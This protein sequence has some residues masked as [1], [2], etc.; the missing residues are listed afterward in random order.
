MFNPGEVT[1]RSWSVSFYDN[2][3]RKWKYGVL[4][5]TP[6]YIE[7]LEE[8]TE[9]AHPYI[10]LL[11][12]YD[13]TDIKKSLTGLV[14]R[15]L[16]ITL[17][18][19]TKYWVSSL[20]DQTS[21][22]N[23]L[24]YFQHQN[25]FSEAR[26]K[27][28][29][30]TQKSFVQTEMGRKL[31]HSVHD[32]ERVL[33]NAVTV[34]HEQGTQIESSLATMHDINNDLDIADSIVSGLDSWLGK[35]KI[36]QQYKR[37]SLEI[38]QSKDLPTEL[39]YEILYT[40]LDMG[41]MNYQHLGILRV[42]IQGL[43]IMTEK[44]KVVHNFDWRAI[45]LVKV[46]SLCEI[47]VTQYRIGQQDLTYDFVCTNFL[48]VLRLLDAKLKSKV[49]FMEDVF[50]EEKVKRMRKQKPLIDSTGMAKGELFSK[51]DD[52]TPICYDTVPA[53]LAQ[54]SPGN[55]CQEGAEVL[56]QK[57]IVTDEEVAEISQTLQ[58]IKSVALSTQQELDIQ[59]DN[60]EKLTDNVDKANQRVKET[61][62][63]I[64]KLT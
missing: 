18:D 52:E 20:A 1:I 14:Y 8:V 19:K 53:Y 50:K 5:L 16:V 42:C 27:T 35:W 6:E 23:V 62:R 64:N 4:K 51:V 36:P 31:L 34:L 12:H 57:Q 48:P 39:D 61:V 2:E 37:E 43:F 44:Q 41:K 59:M 15:A 24:Q 54:P 11:H 55:V 46:L 33:N 29:T 28:Q 22:Y 3:S 63:H 32:S 45:S 26:K 47:T 30:D 58:N 40:K 60:I 10:R 9:T 17:V 7:F 21:L 25:L 13:V 56:C 49:E 38:V